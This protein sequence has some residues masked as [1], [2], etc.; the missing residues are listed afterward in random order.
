MTPTNDGKLHDLYNALAG[1]GLIGLVATV[2]IASTLRLVDDLGPQIGDIIKFDSAKKG[3]PDMQK[4]IAVVR[5]GGLT[6]VSCV[7]DPH[8]M[9]TSGGSLV[10]KAMQTK[11]DFIFGVDWVGTHTSDG[12]TDCGAA[13]EFRLSRPEV[14]AL[15]LAAGN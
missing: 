7:L 8:I 3:L 10:I 12:Q 9:L 13:A 11:P 14:V 2:I 6:A 1:L 5:V 15:K 4:P